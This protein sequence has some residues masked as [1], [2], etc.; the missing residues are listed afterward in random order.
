MKKLVLLLINGELGLE[1][2]RYLIQD[3]KSEISGIVVNSD[4]KRTPEYISKIGEIQLKNQTSFRVFVFDKE[5]WATEEFK[6][7]LARTNLAVVA[8]FG[9]LIPPKVISSLSSNI[10]NLHPSLLPIG[11]GA[12]PIA[13]AIMER[14][15]QGATIHVVEET[16]DT[17]PI[18]LQSEIPSDFGMSSG[19]IYELATQELMNLFIQFNSTWPEKLPHRDQEGRFTYH[20]AT[21]LERLREEFLNNSQNAEHVFRAVQALTFSDGRTMRIRLQNGALWEITLSAIQ[22]QEGES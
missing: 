11:R 21:E 17:G 1:I 9:H 19:Q 10:V 12:D 3:P 2:V 13:W 7:V 4:K 8:L 18:I 20:T 22:I 16:L 6:S 15:K 14:E 5:L